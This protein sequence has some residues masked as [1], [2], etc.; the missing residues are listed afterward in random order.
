MLELLV[1]PY[2]MDDE[3]LVGAYYALFT[4]YPHLQRS[5][6]TLPIADRAAKLRAK[7][8]LRTPDS[9]QAAT[10]IAASATALISNDRAFRKI[11]DFEVLILDDLVH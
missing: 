2:R 5:D 11:H 7:Y 1:Q 3:D 9:I 4:T 6:V 8:N 10:A